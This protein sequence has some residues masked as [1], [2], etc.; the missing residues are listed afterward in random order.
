[1]SKVVPGPG[2]G[3]KTLVPGPG[4]KFVFWLRRRSNQNF[5]L[6][7][8]GTGTQTKLFLAEPQTTLFTRNENFY[9]RV[10]LLLNVILSQLM[11]YKYS[12]KTLQIPLSRDSQSGSG[13]GIGIKIFLLT[14]TG[15]GVGL[16]F[17]DRDRD[18]T[19]KGWSRSCLDSE[20]PLTGFIR[21]IILKCQNKKKLE[22]ERDPSAFCN[23]QRS[24]AYKKP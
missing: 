8:I 23:I 6:T 7:E 19:E 10:R 11:C 16:N 18:G 20:R 22:R 1:M 15:M 5:V 21:V 9:G 24:V 4:Q 3:K 14:R 13:T 2:P 12:S 17:S